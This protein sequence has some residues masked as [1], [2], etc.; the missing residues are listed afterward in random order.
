[1]NELRIKVVGLGGFGLST[2]EEISYKYA[3]L[4]Y[5]GL[6]NKIDDINKS[7]LRDKILL[8]NG[9]TT[10]H[11]PE[12]GKRRIQESMD[13]IKKSLENND[14]VILITALGYG[15][16]SGGA[17]II[18]KLAKDLGSYVISI[19]TTPFSFEG[20][21]RDSN[22]KS[23]L[24]ELKKSSDSLI[25]IS[26]QKLIKGIVKP[27]NGVEE[28]IEEARNL[29]RHIV[30]SIDN[31]INSSS[32]FNEFKKINELS[33][34]TYFG[35]GAVMGEEN[36]LVALRLAAKPN[37]IDK[38]LSNANKVLISIN[39]KTEVSENTLN[40]IYDELYNIIGRDVEIIYTYT[41]DEL[42][43]GILM[44]SLF[45]SGDGKAETVLSEFDKLKDAINPNNL[46]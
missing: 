46:M 21:N 1:M 13:E 26:N 31:V 3:G 39:Y 25:V 40:L 6:S 43:S 45:A 37:I 17:P 18:S 34:E 20:Q 15:T 2:V 12:L 11:S 44:L 22:A 8:G 5:L 41:M 24:A 16:G 38:S 10:N 35:V 36:A 23:A 30:I 28:K 27:S 32:S 29:V 33:K 42:S 19:C 7:P 14:V 4:T 9:V